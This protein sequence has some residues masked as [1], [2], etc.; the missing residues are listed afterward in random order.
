MYVCMCV[1]CLC[2][3]CICVHVYALCVYASVC[4][5]CRRTRGC[6]GAHAEVRGYCQIQT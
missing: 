6:Y 3:V 1:M 5:V 2:V 4:V